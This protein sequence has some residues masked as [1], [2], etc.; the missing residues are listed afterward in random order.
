LS[1]TAPDPLASDAPATP[2]RRRARGRKAGDATRSAPL[3]AAC[4]RAAVRCAGRLSFRTIHRLGGALGL[5]LDRLP[6]Q[7]R[8]ATRINLEL[9]LPELGTA[10]R[11]ALARRS[12]IETGRTMLE[13][14][15]LWSWPRERVLALVREV[16]GLDRLHAALAR[17]KGVLVLTP[18]LGAWEL[19]GL[20][21]GSVAPLTAMYKP[22]PVREMEAFYTRARERCGA[23]L[24]PADASGVRALHRA[25]RAG[26]MA[27]VLP[28]QDPGRGSG[29][30]APFF[31]V[32]ANTTT[33]VA[34]LAHRTGA[35]VVLVWSERLPA[36]A[37]F[38]VHVV[39]PQ[40]SD[41][42]APQVE[43][44]V[45]AMNRELERLIRSAPEQYL[46][47]YKRFRHRPGGQPNPYRHGLPSR[48]A[49]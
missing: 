41:F 15:A 48:A 40:A 5:A 37:G 20:F 33:L 34:K 29:V 47:S 13:L 8:R 11:R 12:L 25:L 19:T 36:G 10:A 23:R 18:H 27:G 21:T 39:E 17:G 16:R 4:G 49:G 28:D 3:L 46:W 43:R 35:A 14:G 6:T 7:E 42:D 26:E 31:G 44:A 1:E 2:H 45:A 30:F 22:P 9:C 32:L 24:V 38:R